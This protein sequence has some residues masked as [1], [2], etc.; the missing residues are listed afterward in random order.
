MKALKIIGIVL[1]SII[2]I[3]VVVGY[4][5]PEVAQTER[6]II[7]KAPIEVVFDQA[8]DL[9]NRMKWSP[10]ENVDSTMSHEMGSISKG[11]GAS[12][13]WTSIT[14]GSGTLTYTEVI[15][16]EKIVSKRNFGDQGTANGVL[17]FEDAP[18]G[19]K[20]TWEFSTDPISNPFA[21]LAM[22]ILTPQMEMMF[23]QGLEG[24]KN[25][26]EENAQN[27]SASMPIEELEVESFIYISLMDSAYD[28]EM[29][30]HYDQAYSTLER[31]AA[32]HNLEITGQPLSVTHRWDEETS[33]GVFEPAMPV[34]K[35]VEGNGEVMVKESYSGK[36]LKATYKGSYDD[37]AETWTALMT[38]L[39]SEGYEANG[40][41]WKI[42][43]T[44]TIQEPDTSKWIT[45]IYMP[46]K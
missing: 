40:L 5:Q 11:Q 29:S 36:A 14:Q 1:V 3:V 13:T 18:D 28:D 17:H 45:E 15:P 39:H 30:A 34:N 9:E 22:A 24:L 38:K 2:L 46:V 33:F 6:S 20:V 31:F 10:W 41:P 35:T 32:E 16:N 43:V 26:A 27:G 8:N 23:D 12:Y 21:R 44:D 42:Y 4:I 37:V 7:V 19:I 25:Q